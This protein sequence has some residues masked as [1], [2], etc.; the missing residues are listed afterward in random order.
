MQY[1]P[2]CIEF[3]YYLTTKKS[4]IMGKFQEY[5]SES[6]SEKITILLVVKMVKNSLSLNRATLLIVYRQ[7]RGM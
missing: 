6:E 4:F 3:F 5:G 7:G 1:F 2:K